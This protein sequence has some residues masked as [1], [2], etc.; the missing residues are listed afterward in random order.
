MALGARTVSFIFS[1]RDSADV[2]I[3]PWQ[4]YLERLYKSVPLFIMLWNVL[5]IQ[6]T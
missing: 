4:Y 6:N 2:S 5:F 3:V 1:L